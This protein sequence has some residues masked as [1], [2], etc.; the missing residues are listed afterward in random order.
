[1]SA[2]DE[3]RRRLK[4]IRRF[5][6][7]EHR[8]APDAVLAAYLDQVMRAEWEQAMFPRWTT[9]VTNMGMTIVAV[10]GFLYVM[11]EGRFRVPGLSGGEVVLV[12]AAVML[13]VAVGRY[14]YNRAADQRRAVAIAGLLDAEHGRAK[15]C[16]HCGYDLRHLDSDR[17]PECGHLAHVVPPGAQATD[18]L[19]PSKPKHVNR[20]HPRLR[21]LHPTVAR[22]VVRHL[23]DDHHHD[24]DG[25]AKGLLVISLAV[26]AAVIWLLAALVSGAAA[27]L[28]AVWLVIAAAVVPFVIQIP[29]FRRRVSR[30]L[31]KPAIPCWFCGTTMNTPVCGDCEARNLTRDEVAAASV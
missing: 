23:R 29:L 15:V 2:A 5:L 16:V 20:T 22:G 18:Q 27:G 4:G 3:L 30:S 7:P 9:Q 12:F 19:R 26:A 8:R 17:C 25:I 10:I 13:A 28:T 21:D 11:G 14:V 6:K 1:M 31:D 24:I